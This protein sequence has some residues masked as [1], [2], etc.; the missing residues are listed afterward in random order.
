MKLPP[1]RM[2]LPLSAFLPILIFELIMVEA[3]TEEVVVLKPNP[4]SVAADKLANI[5]VFDGFRLDFMNMSFCF[6]FDDCRITKVA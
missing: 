4:I 6:R 3:F 1:E 2:H 5:S